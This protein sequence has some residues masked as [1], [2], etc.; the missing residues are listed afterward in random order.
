MNFK[1]SICIT[2]FLAA[3]SLCRAVVSTGF[4]PAE[5][6]AAHAFL[7]QQGINTD[8]C[9][10][11]MGSNDEYMTIFGDPWKKIS[12]GVANSR[13]HRWM[14]S[15]V[16][17]WSTESAQIKLSD[18]SGLEAYYHSQ[19]AALESGA[20]VLPL[21]APSSVYTPEK[22]QVKPLLG[23]IRFS[24]KE[25]YNLFCPILKG[26]KTITGCVPTA[27]AQ[28]MAYYRFPSV[29]RGVYKYR[30]H[31][32]K[33]YIEKDFS[34]VTMDWAKYGHDDYTRHCDTLSKMYISQLITAITASLGASFGHQ[35]TSASLDNARSGLIEFWGFDIG[36]RYCQSYNRDTIVG[37]IHRELDQGRPTIVATKDHAF[38]ADGCKD[39]FLHFNLGW[40]G[41]YN[42]YYRT[43]ISNTND[44]IFPFRY[45]LTGIMPDRGQHVERTLKLKKPNTLRDSLSGDEQL[46]ITAL[47][48]SGPL[49]NDDV[50]VLRYM[51]GAPGKTQDYFA[52]SGRLQVLDLSK[53]KFKTETKTSFYAEV[54][55]GPAGRSWSVDR[56]TGE[57]TNTHNFNFDHMSPQAWT[58]Y[59][60]ASL[61]DQPGYVVRRNDGVCTIY[62]HTEAN[63]I[64]PYMFCLCHNLRSIRIPLNTSDVGSVS[65]AGCEL[66]SDICLPA[67]TESVGDDAFRATRLLKQVRCLHKKTEQ[68]SPKA[69]KKG[70]VDADFVFEPDK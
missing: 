52:P 41:L 5:W 34:Q 22:E 56:V 61:N 16:L 31:D 15:P 60:Q 66:L 7:L 37:L 35:N 28:I 24:Q 30:H 48:L 23:G 20:A 54:A 6:K 53:A 4:P 42:G 70:Y 17:F 33:H 64:S 8:S 45:V 47:T 38:L 67:K 29:G 39:G 68:F 62:C 26:K 2:F 65:F 49:G 50:R 59:V 19:L 44:T 13:F 10:M 63:M 14:D 1:K 43:H 40:G 46:H 3:V 69:F 12:I 36:I 25:P 18:I 32:R 58:Y 51:L 9:R 11:R 55:H 57:K 27:C 21:Q